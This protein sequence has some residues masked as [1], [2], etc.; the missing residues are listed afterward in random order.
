MEIIPFDKSLISEWKY[1]GI[2]SEISGEMICGI[3]SF[4]SSLGKGFVGIADGKV[5][6]VGGV[7]KLWAGWGSA[8]LFLN[9]EAKNYKKSVFKGILSKIN[10]LVK[11][12]D[13]E[14]LGIQCLDGSM[15]ANRLLS[16]LGFVKNKEIKMALYGRKIK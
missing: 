1:D 3:A 8:W 6:G 14:V 2:E 5:I 4:Y 15:E 9:K 7:Y 11:L 10:E 16:H 12:Y 13:I